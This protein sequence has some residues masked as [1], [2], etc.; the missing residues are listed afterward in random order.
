MQNTVIKLMLIALAA[1]VAAGC[2]S[3]FN[4]PERAASVADEH[5]ISVDSQVITLT[6]DVDPTTSD[7]SAI[8]KARL[9]AFANSYLRSGHGPLTVTAPSGTSDDFDGQEVAADIRGYL[10]EIGVPWSAMTGATYRAGNDGRGD[11]L[12]VSYTHYV[13][14]PSACGDWSDQYMR[15]FRNLR[16]PNFGCATM[17]NYAAMVADPHDLIAPVGESPAD[18][19]ARTRVIDAYRKGEST[20]SET[21]DEINEQIAEQ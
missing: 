4:G 7:I 18:A 1:A 3:V 15:D 8:D 14:T 10:N 11:Q 21:D 2:S 17:N 16:S 13:A 19:M 9:R 20:A 6:I 5:P 12:I